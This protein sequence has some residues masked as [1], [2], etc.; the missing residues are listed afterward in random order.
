[1]PATTASRPT[2]AGRGTGSTTLCSWTLCTAPGEN[3][4]ADIQVTPLTGVR[5]TEKTEEKAEDLKRDHY[6]SENPAAK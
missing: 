1:L 4:K 6:W 3:T 2:G 5:G